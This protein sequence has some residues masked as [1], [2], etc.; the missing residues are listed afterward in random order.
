M[1][2][3]FLKRKLTLKIR[4]LCKFGSLSTMCEVR[5]NYSARKNE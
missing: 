1:E 5:V 3:D 2:R 4:L